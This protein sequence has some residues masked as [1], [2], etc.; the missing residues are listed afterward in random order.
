MKRLLWVLVIMTL[1]L[2]SASPA[3]AANNRYIVRSGG[4]LSLQTACNL[5]G[6]TVVEALDGTLGQVFL[7]TSAVQ[8]DLQTLV[9]LLRSLTLGLEDVSAEPDQ[10]LTVQS[11]T[12][13]VVPSGLYDRTPVSYYGTVVWEGYAHQPAASIIRLSDTQQTFKVT[14]A[15]IIADIDTGVDFNHPALQKVLLPGYDFT[16]NQPFG[17]EMT[18]LALQPSSEQGQAG[19]VNQSTVAV[20]DQS[21]VAVLDTN[22]AYVAFGHGTMVAGILHMVAPTAQLM[23]LKAFHSD[24]TGYL[25]DVL[26]AV[27]YGVQNK[28]KVINMSFDFTSSSQELSRAMSYA[29]RAGVICV[30]SAGNDGKDELVY[31]A[32]L[33]NVVMGVASTSDEDKRSSF[34]NFGADIVWVAAP[35]EAIITTYPFGTYAAGW[36]T[37]FS[38]P[39]VS[40]GAALLVS[41]KSSVNQSQAAQA[42]GHAEYISPDLNHGRLDL[43]QA[44]TAWRQAL[45]KH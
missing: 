32:A 40:G 24:G 12:S 37:S 17:S 15:G 31:P 28:A 2:G 21:T 33:T 6:C 14:G 36:G 44:V 41:V 13:Y 9:N 3:A 1:L 16:R 11:S 4:L 8:L 39:M 10:L 22:P 38:A 23:P 42:L 27:Y 19:W 35:G 7:V 43:Y 45:E 34:S 29:N 30:A 5:L 25:S 18:D 20:L 26:R